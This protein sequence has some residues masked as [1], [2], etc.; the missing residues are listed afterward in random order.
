[1]RIALTGIFEEVNTF[2]VQSMG[3]AK[4]TGNMTTGFQKWSGQGLIDDYK[5]S[6][7]YMGGY[8]AAL[9][10]SAEV[11]IVPT[12]F[13]SY[14]AGP[15]I[16]GDDYKKMK[17]DILDGLKAAMPLDAVAIQFHGAGVAEGVDD[18]EG[19][20]AAAIR[21]LVGPKAKLVCSLDHHSNLTDHHLQQ[22]DL[23]E[24]VH[25][26][27]HV[28]MYDT[29]YRIGKLLPDMVKGGQLP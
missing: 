26:Y 25:H 2:A 13:Y 7:T 28:D 29:A 8:I 4:I 3:L 12:A 5:G 21:Q 6:K 19:D 27:P 22:M 1:M 9:E 23:I 15:T 14:S 17:Q 24:L 11:E 20:V 10:E 16:A 18:V